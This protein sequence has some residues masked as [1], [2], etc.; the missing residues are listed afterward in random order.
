MSKSK[1]LYLLFICLSVSHGLRAQFLDYGSDPA[2]FKWNIVRLPHYNLIYPQGT[3]SMAYRYALYL[4]NAYPYIQK[5]IGKPMKARFPVILHP[6]NMQSNGM[7]SWAPRR[8]ELITTPSSDLGVQSWDKH[9]VLHE[10]RHVFQTGK[11]MSGIFKPFYYLIGEQAAGV[12]S[13]FLP[14]WFLEGDAVG[15]ETAMS[16]GGR[17]R[18]PEFNMAYR[19]QMLGGDKFYSFD[20]WLLGSYKN[21]AGTYYA[22][23][24]DLTSYARQRYGGDIWD[25]ST[26]RYV[27]NIFFQGSFKH[28]T[29]SSFKQLHQDTFDFLR[30]EWERQDTCSFVPFYHSSDKKEYTSYRYPCLINDSTVV[31]VKSGLKDINSLVTIVNG[32][33]KRLSYIGNINSRLDHH[34]RQIYWTEIVPGL[35]WTHENYSALKCYDLE[36]G[37][38]RDITPRQRYLSPSVDKN[39][40]VAAVSRSTVDGKNQLVLVRLEDG[41]E[42]FSFQVPGNAFIKEL[43]FTDHDEVVAVAVTDAGISLLLFTLSSGQWKELLSTV[44]VNITSP[45]WKNGR[46][47]FESGVNGTNNIYCLDP[48]DRQV[49]RLTCA[50]FG[51]FDPSF[52]HSGNRLF[53]ADYQANGY[54]IA[55]LPIDSLLA[56]KT[57]LGHPVSMPFVETLARQENFNMDS[58]RL[59]PTDFQPKRYRKGL[60]TFKIHSWA[61][62]Y[63]DVAE[64]M[65]TSASDLSTIVKPGATIMSQNT[66]N[67][68]IMQA[69]WYYHKNYHHGKLSFIYQG[70]FP[71]I[72]L[73]ADYGDK[74]INMAWVQNEHGQQVTKAYRTDRTLLE[75]ETRVYLPFNLTRNHRIRGIQPAATYY[76]TNDKYQEYTGKKF[77]NFQYFL[78]E[79]LFYNYRRKA[80]RDIIPRNG[81]QLRLQYLMTP[82]NT[83]NFGNLYAVRLTTYW[84]GILRNHG[85]MLRLGYQYQD[86]GGRALYLPKH[87][88]DTPRG[89]NFQYQTCQQWGFKGDYAFPILLPDLSIGSLIYIRRI[90]ANLF[91]D[92]SRN[93]AQSKGSWT[94][95]SSCGGD[96]I[97]DWNVL[98]MSYPI[99]AGARFIQPLD[100]GK[101]QV[102]ALFSISF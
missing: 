102:E 68:A 36:K 37:R 18:L 57:D 74:A 43:T 98:R 1:C 22:L 46:I 79:V 84:P 42:L 91:Y 25:K 33:E 24:Y 60:H 87:L 9:L 13:F 19:A 100:Y 39:G 27:H 38:I 50:R 15:T 31:A 40:K 92:L 12:A 56:E 96:L 29:G 16:N 47:Y 69:G 81:Y 67:T 52:S 88:L 64:A 55:S 4:E 75:T 2:R 70:W 89:Y 11:V 80:Q 73:T 28:Y 77:H 17:G 63:Y 72:N 65:N 66:L 10:S 6:A 95:Q 62:F 78:P 8:M 45:V 14:V 58:V 21:Y 49:Y 35:R 44:S 30:K 32:K 53:F 94:H 85:L 23:G 86:L 93:Q 48:S 51:A 59:E 34:D 20:K 82:F 61:P 71:V 26:S 7:V 99:T 41:K 97:F 83:V 3:D 90:R 54:R 101:F 76:F 5:T